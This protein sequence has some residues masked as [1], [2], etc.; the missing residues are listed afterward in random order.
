MARIRSVH[1][2]LW[3]DESFVSITMAA[4][5]L[6][7]GVWNEC[8]DQGAFEW[9]PLTLKM[10]LLPADN[11]DVAALLAELESADIVRSYQVAGKKYGAVRNFAKYQRPKKPNSIYP[12]TDELRTY[13]GHSASSSEPDT[14]DDGP[15]SP[16]VPHQFPT[17]GEKSPQ[18]EE[19]GWNKEEEGGSTISSVEPFISAPDPSP[20]AAQATK[21]DPRGARL[22]ENWEPS[23]QDRAFAIANGLNPDRIR[24]EFRDYWIAQPG[25]SGRRS[26]WSATFRNR[27]R[28]CVERRR[29]PIDARSARPAINGATQLRREAEARGEKL[30]EI[31][32]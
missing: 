28:Q 24:D 15:G 8:D 6:A 31:P 29:S 10:R 18:M 5:L 27:V 32:W 2:G 9:K 14:D 30:A 13:A 26:D 11:V 17:A 16:P 1:P 21:S 22:S 3:T 7:I 20:P 12:M 25:K 4:R 19:G 23:E